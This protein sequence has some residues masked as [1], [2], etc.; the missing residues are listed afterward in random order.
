M[1]S[2]KPKHPPKFCPECGQAI[3]DY[4]IHINDYG[5]LIYDIYCK[6]CNW[7]GDVVPYEDLRWNVTEALIRLVEKS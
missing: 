2:K 5:D 6:N 7:M 4:D 1:Y 3:N